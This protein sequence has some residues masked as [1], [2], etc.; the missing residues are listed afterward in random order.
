MSDDERPLNSMKK[1]RHTSTPPEDGGDGSGG[2]PPDDS[3]SDNRGSTRCAARS[4]SDDLSNE[5]AHVPAQATSSGIP[6]IAQK[7]RSMGHV[8]VTEATAFL[9]IPFGKNARGRMWDTVRKQLDVTLLQRGDWPCPEDVVRTRNACACDRW[10]APSVS[11]V[12][13][14]AERR[15]AEAPAVVYARASTGTVSEVRPAF[16]TVRMTC[17]TWAQVGGASGE[18]V[19]GVLSEANLAER[20]V[21]TAV[22]AA[23]S[24]IADVARCAC[25]G[26]CLRCIRGSL[27]RCRVSC[28]AFV[29]RCVVCVACVFSGGQKRVLLRGTA[30]LRKRRRGRSCRMC[31]R[32]TRH[33]KL[34][35]SNA[36]IG[37]LGWAS[38]MPAVRTQRHPVSLC[39]LARGSTHG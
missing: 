37:R 35:L 23:A 7:L 10:R 31:R 2:G 34:H 33:G 12:D 11:A 27:L 17:G 3:D 20:R 25:F 8:S 9:N 15:C 21:A 1:R 24:T 5:S 36:P 13:S 6:A 26:K 16:C 32:W 39:R 30:G 28:V 29:C 4:D 19:R 22:L 18:K 14:V 38:G